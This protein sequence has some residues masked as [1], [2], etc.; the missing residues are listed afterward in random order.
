M[1]V[2][3]FNTNGKGT[4]FR[5]IYNGAPIEGMLFHICPNCGFCG[6]GRLFAMSFDNPELLADVKSLMPI[7]ESSLGHKIKRAMECLELLLNYGVL[8]LNQWELANEWLN[9]YWWAETP[10]QEQNAGH[11]VIGYFETALRRNLVPPDKILGIK[12]LIGEIHRRIG[13]KDAANAFFD[14]VIQEFER[15]GNRGK[16]YDLAVQQKNNPEE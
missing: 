4:D 12:Y 11:V 13:E 1:V 8:N 6:R 7:D 15:R 2:E 9:A 10:E 16:L 5:P 14:E 3:S